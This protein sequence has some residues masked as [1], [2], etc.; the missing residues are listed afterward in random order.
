M[1]QTRASGCPLADI[2]NSMTAGPLGPV[3]MQDVGLTEKLQHFDR[4]K[5]PAR[6]VHALGTG[7]YGTFVVTNDISKYTRADL[8]S[9]VG[10]KTPVFARFSGIFTEQGDPDTSRDPRGFAI[11]FYTKEG[12]WDLLAINTPVFAVRDAKPGPDAVHAFKRDPRSGE[13]NPAQ[14]WDYVVNHPEGTFQTLM[15]YSDLYGTPMS[16]RTMNAYGCNTYSLINADMKRVWVKFHLLSQQGTRGLSVEQAKLIAGEDPNFMSRDLREAIAMGKFPRWKMCIQVMEEEEG[17]KQPFAFDCTK[18]WSEERYP[19]IEVGELEMNVNP[20]NYFSE[21]EQVALSPTNIVP[22]IGFSPDK[23]LQGRLFIYDDT[24]NHRL[25]PN[26][27]QF[28]INR[29]QNAEVH[30]FYYGGRGNADASNKFPHY[31]PSSLGRSLSANKI[32]AEPPL[33]VTGPVG[34]YDLPGEGTDEDYYAQPK[35]WYNSL[36]EDDRTHIQKNIA[37]S[38]VRAPEIIHKGVFK[39]LTKVDSHLA[40]RVEILLKDQLAGR[41]PITAAQKAWMEARTTLGLPTNTINMSA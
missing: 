22:G 31:T 28:P 11:K 32:A 23:L 36:T 18:I 15:L 16:Y 8:F 41:A 12:N 38:L 17:F 37:L 33:K 29:P 4:E 7:A 5:I 25:G 24:Q 6:N 10:K 2:K 39:M 13:W 19:L 26:F 14:T 27:K 20:V 3:M 35:Q 40:Q 9:S 34:Y 21:V 30:N 1:Y